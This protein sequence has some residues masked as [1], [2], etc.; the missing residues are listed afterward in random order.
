MEWD[1]LSSK[2]SAPPP[3]G[4]LEAHEISKGRTVV[5]NLHVCVSDIGRSA[6]GT[7]GRGH[8]GLVSCGDERILALARGVP[9]R[10][11][12]GRHMLRKRMK[13]G[14]TILGLGAMLVLG[15]SSCALQGHGT[16]WTWGEV[17]AYEH[18]P[19]DSGTQGR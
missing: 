10:L 4:S 7:R 6:G 18:S 14:L 13:R 2:M 9:T 19:I 3:V 1:L 16:D 17:N 8:V 15:V 5:R 11:E 12:R